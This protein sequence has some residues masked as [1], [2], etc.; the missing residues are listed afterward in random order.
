MEDIEEAINTLFQTHCKYHSALQ[1]LHERVFE[2]FEEHYDWEFF[3]LWFGDDSYFDSIYRQV[4]ATIL[5]PEVLTPEQREIVERKGRNLE[6]T[7]KKWLR[8]WKDAHP[9]LPNEKM[10]IECIKEKMYAYIAYQLKQRDLRQ[11]VGNPC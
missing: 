2:R 5:S 3:D 11:I 4:F 8:K 7:I 10:P 1:Y 9:N 6:E